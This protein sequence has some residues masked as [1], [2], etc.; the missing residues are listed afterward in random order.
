[1]EDAEDVKRKAE[2]RKRAKE[3]RK[4]KLEELLSHGAKLPVWVEEG[5]EDEELMEAGNGDGA[6]DGEQKRDIVDMDRGGAVWDRHG[7]RG[8]VENRV[9]KG[10]RAG[11][12]DG[13]RRDV[14]ERRASEVDVGTG[15]LEQ[16]YAEGDGGIC[17]EAGGVREEEAASS[18]CGPPTRRNGKKT[19]G[20]EA[21]AEDDGDDDAVLWAGADDGDGDEE[22]VEIESDEELVMGGEVDDF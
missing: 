3:R 15:V 5:S 16:A 9:G 11:L 8:C 22:R 19:E 2:K 18:D 7:A 4:K 1:M 6:G 13:T 17:A 20:D 14:W 21:E 10:V 12:E